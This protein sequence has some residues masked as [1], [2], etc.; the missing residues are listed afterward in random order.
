MLMI[1]YLSLIMIQ[2]FYHN[3]NTFLPFITKII[4]HSCDKFTRNSGIKFAYLMN[5]ITKS[6]IK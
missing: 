1:H 3:I 5:E 6:L 2:I 4:S